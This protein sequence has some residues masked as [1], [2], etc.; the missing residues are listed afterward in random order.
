MHWGKN[1]VSYPSQKSLGFLFPRGPYPLHRRFRFGRL[2]P[3][4][5]HLLEPNSGNV[6]RRNHIPVMHRSIDW[7]LPLPDPQGQLRCQHRTPVLGTKDN[8]ILTARYDRVI[9]M[10]LFIR[11]TVLH[12]LPKLDHF[13]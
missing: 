2:P 13:F 6:L 8:V 4:L 7:A 3:Y 5:F 12:I 10:G 9:A 1:K 11:L